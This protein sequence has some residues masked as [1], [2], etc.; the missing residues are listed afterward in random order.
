MGQR[1]PIRK[2]SVTAKSRSVRRGF[3]RA[4]IVAGSPP[5]AT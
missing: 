2:D 1:T 3:A 5:A 4:A